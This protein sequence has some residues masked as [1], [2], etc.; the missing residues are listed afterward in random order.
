V[1]G[2]GVHGGQPSHPRP[3]QHKLD[4]AAIMERTFTAA[5]CPELVLQVD[6]GNYLAR[7][8]CSC[9][10]PVTMASTPL[11]AAQAGDLYRA[12]KQD[13]DGELLWN[14]RCL[15]PRK[16]HRLPLLSGGDERSFSEPAPHSSLVSA[17]CRAGGA[18]MGRAIALDIARGLTFLHSNNI[19]HM[20][21]KTPNGAARTAN[22]PSSTTAL[23]LCMAHFR[24]G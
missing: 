22:L 11:I 8:L 2:H 7:E 9:C 16:M 3:I 12:L 19:A 10:L 20:D 17:A 21:L 18:G 15:L 13:K 14:K 1:A 5:A 4:K 23:N 6:C 24:T